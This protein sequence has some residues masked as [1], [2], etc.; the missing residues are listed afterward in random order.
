MAATCS[1]TRG[2]NFIYNDKTQKIEHV[3]KLD[4]NDTEI[5]T[6]NKYGLYNCYDKE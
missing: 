1:P 2:G 4:I 5:C 6:T 3:N